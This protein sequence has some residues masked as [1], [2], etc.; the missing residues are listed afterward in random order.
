MR[1]I[2]YDT[3]HSVGDLHGLGKRPLE[4]LLGWPGLVLGSLGWHGAGD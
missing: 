4:G 2:A 1:V 3:Q